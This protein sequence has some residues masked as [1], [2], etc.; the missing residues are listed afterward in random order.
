MSYNE[1]DDN[2]KTEAQLQPLNEYATPGQIAGG[3][4]DSNLPTDEA[5][6]VGYI[7]HGTYQSDTLYGDMG[8][9]TL[10]G[11]SGHDTLYGGAG[12]DLLNGGI[13]SY[14]D[15]DAL[16]GGDTLDGGDGIDMVD[17]STRGFYGVTV[18]LGL[19]TAKI[20]YGIGDDVLIGIE[21]VVGSIFKDSLTGANVANMLD[22]GGGHDTLRGLGGGDTLH[23]GSGNDTMAGGL[24][25]NLMLGGDGNDTLVGDNSNDLT[26]DGLW[27]SYLVDGNHDTLYGGVGNDTLDGGTGNDMLYGDDGNDSLHGGRYE[28]YTF[29]SWRVSNNDTLDGGSGNDTMDGFDGADVMN[30]GHGNDVMYGGHGYDV[31]NGGHGNDVMFGGDGR[32][33][34]DAGSGYDTM[35][36]GKSC[37]V[38]FG[39]DGN[40]S[41]FGGDEV[42]ADTLDSMH[43]QILRDFY[44]DNVFD[45]YQ[46]AGDT[47]DGGLGNDFI[48]GG[49]GNDVL[50]GG[51]GIDSLFGDAGDDILHLN[52]STTGLLDSGETILPTH[53]GMLDGGDGF[54]TLVLD[55]HAGSGATLDLSSLVTAGKISGIERIDITGDADD[56]N[57]LTLK[58]SDVFST[59]GGNSLYIEGDA[60]DTVTMA[61]EGWSASA[62]VTFDGQTYRH[63][64]NQGYNLYIDAEIDQQNI[65][66]S[67]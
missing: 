1:F 11:G 27:C 38:M 32:D 51:G 14:Y 8:D 65:I 31:M 21:N 28:W 16:H 61:D 23:G 25:K 63:Y 62:D 59:S 30:G 56:N 20:N 40:D 24:A 67:C 57:T 46:T 10:Y 41:M 9:E 55:S 13:D 53:I 58:V 29:M 5:N 18:D 54:D 66:H 35:D 64:V 19:G 47:M 4:D 44:G 60:G 52:L 15:R 22:G 6:N 45:G 48:R 49:D 36:G 43:A 26:G 17:Y 7:L 39:G 2:L 34:M 50:Y 37:D 33:T 12:N 3:V 42:Y